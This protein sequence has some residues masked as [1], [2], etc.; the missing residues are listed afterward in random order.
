RHRNTGFPESFCGNRNTS[1]PHPDADTSGNACITQEDISVS[2]VLSRQRR[3]FLNKNK[4]TI[5]HG[6]ITPEMEQMYSEVAVVSDSE[7]TPV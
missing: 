7:A 4:R 5:S 6:Y 2:R 1:L 3:S